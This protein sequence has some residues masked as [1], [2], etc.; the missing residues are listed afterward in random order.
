MISQHSVS[1]EIAS[2]AITNFK[3]FV[4]SN[5]EVEISDNEQKQSAVSFKYLK[6]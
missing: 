2:H 4:F 3:E 6:K 5:N 1:N